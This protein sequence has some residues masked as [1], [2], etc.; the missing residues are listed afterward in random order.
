MPSWTSD[1]KSECPVSHPSG[2]QTQANS[3]DGNGVG[4]KPRV[5]ARRGQATDPHS[6]AER[7]SV[8]TRS[9]HFMIK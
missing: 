3:A 5:R 2:V 6:I 7:V 9:V 8:F 4:M 1:N